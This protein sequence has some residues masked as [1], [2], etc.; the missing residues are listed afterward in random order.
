MSS[1][2]ADTSPRSFSIQ[3]GSVELA[4]INNH[5]KEHPDQ[6][7]L[8][9]QLR[10][11]IAAARIQQLKPED[12]R[13]VDNNTPSSI[14]NVIKYN[15]EGLKSM[16]ALT[17]PAVLINPLSSCDYIGARMNG[18]DVLTVG[19]RT[20][21][22]IFA[23]MAAGFNSAKIRGL[24]LISYSPFVDVG[25]MHDMPYRDNR[26]DVVILGW[27]LAY[28]T[29]NPK[30]VA[31]VLRVARPGAFIAV[32]C[33]YNPLSNEEVREQMKG[34]IDSEVG[35]DVTRFD[36]TDDILDLFEGH[37]DRVVFRHDVHP[38]MRSNTGAIMVIFQLPL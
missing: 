24:D 34:Q 8:I 6:I 26:F 20:E 18:L 31:E 10:N 3:L 15:I 36:I 37:V 30:A 38:T 27:V 35:T 2:S 25:D 28:S 16:W 1:D 21:A 4:N 14:D 33:E 13:T 11:M 32:G 22:E 12:I 29:D 7:L 19:P 9:P 23:L 17:R 5:L